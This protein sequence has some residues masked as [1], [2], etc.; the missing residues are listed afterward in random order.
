MKVTN[1]FQAFVMGY[2]KMKPF[3]AVHSLLIMI[4]CT[5][6]LGGCSMSDA[7]PHG[8]SE[9]QQIQST[10]ESK[11]IES[12]QPES[13]AAPTASP[14]PEPTPEP[15]KYT[16]DGEE[17]EVVCNQTDFMIYSDFKELE[18]N[19]ELIVIGHFI[20]DAVGKGNASTNAFEITQVLK[21]YTEDD[22]ICIYQRYTVN[23]SSKRIVAYSHLTPMEKGSEWICFLKC[24]DPEDALY[25]HVG[26]T[27]GR[28]PFREI[29]QGKLMNGEYLSKDIG[30]Y[31]AE[32]FCYDIYMELLKEYD[33]QFE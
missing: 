29:D 16:M 8:N 28:Y 32:D 27:M 5:F 19:S 23:K 33:I 3:R 10:D 15:L 6:A 7:G 30:V 2:Y 21:G 4:L 9:K 1:R 14:T 20:E 11:V 26:D 17:Y 24:S 22:V 31:Q 12:P 13:T 25:Y 18:E